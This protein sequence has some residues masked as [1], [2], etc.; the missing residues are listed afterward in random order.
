MATKYKASN[1]NVPPPAA[2][3]ETWASTVETM[4]SFALLFSLVAYMLLPAMLGQHLFATLAAAA[5]A[6]TDGDVSL[7]LGQEKARGMFWF[8]ALSV[9][10]AGYAVV[11]LL[12]WAGVAAIGKPNLRYLV[13]S[14]LCVQICSGD[15]V[16]M[17]SGR[18]P[19]PEQAEV[20]IVFMSGW[21][22]I[23]GIAST[24]FL[25]GLQYSVLA[26]FTL[27]GIAGVVLSLYR[28]GKAR[29]D[30]KLAARPL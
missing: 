28:I 17:A 6:P 12:V 9:S 2:R 7:V 21:V 26:P 8:S 16:R 27:V 29:I 20:P 10:L 25:E 15:L 23:P 1:S 30:R 22:D 13:S 3:V 11:Y 4:V 19:L 18:T 5:G 14:L 24:G